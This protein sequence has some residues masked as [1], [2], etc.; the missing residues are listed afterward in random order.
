MPGILKE[1]CLPGGQH[2][3]LI[4]LFIGRPYNNHTNSSLLLN[5]WV[6]T[7]WDEQKLE[8]AQKYV[9]QCHDGVIMVAFEK[10]LKIICPRVS[11]LGLE[12]LLRGSLGRWGWR[13]VAR[14]DGQADEAWLFH[15]FQPEDL[16][17]SSVLWCFCIAEKDLSQCKW[18]REEP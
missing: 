16:S 7:Q 8:K 14:R 13:E 6:S 15:P 12:K 9:C 4:A 18:P 11:M 3:N 10:M 1:V 17:L 5:Q 2:L